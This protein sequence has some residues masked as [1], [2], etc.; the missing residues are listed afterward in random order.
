M[1]RTRGFSRA[2]PGDTQRGRAVRGLHPGLF[3]G[4]AVRLLLDGHVGPQDGVPGLA[5]RH[6]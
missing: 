6:C 3:R 4:I 5:L 1:I 2:G